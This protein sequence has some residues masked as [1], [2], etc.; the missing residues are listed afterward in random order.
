LNV[1]T[2]NEAAEAVVKI[3]I[4]MRSRRSGEKKPVAHEFFS[5]LPL[6]MTLRGFK[7]NL[8]TNFA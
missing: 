8:I 5:E 1:L 2:L 4:Q 7:L 6:S 3:D